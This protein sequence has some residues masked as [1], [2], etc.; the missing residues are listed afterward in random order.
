[1]LSNRAVESFW[2]ALWL[3]IEPFL[4]FM[5]LASFGIAIRAPFV[6]TGGEGV[7]VG[8]GKNQSG[9]GGGGGG[10]G[11]E[12]KNGVWGGGGGKNQNQNM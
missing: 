1:M 11:G 9:L 2:D 3:G 4:C 8:W 10:G 7:G 6:R 5:V 12:K